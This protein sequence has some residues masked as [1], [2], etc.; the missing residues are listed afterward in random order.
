MLNERRVIA[1]LRVSTQSQGK[2]GLGVDAQR[3]AIARFCEAEGIEI[4]GEH[5][6]IETG[7]GADALDRRP[8][9]AFTLAEARKIKA[10]VIVAELDR[11]SRDVHFVSGL[12]VHKVPFDRGG[13]GRRHRPVYAAPVCS[14]GREG[15]R[16]DFSKDKG[17][18]SGSEG[19]WCNPWQPEA[20]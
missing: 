5:I 3:A 20:C 19:A 1:Y 4:V 8:V 7:K 17:G 15:T 2:S 12:M 11:L 10:A 13:T 9:L 16:D 18:A 6:E 14:T